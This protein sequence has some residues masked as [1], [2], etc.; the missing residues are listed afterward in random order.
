[1]FLRFIELIFQQKLVV[2]YLEQMERH[3][4][5]IGISHKTQ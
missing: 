5:S 2:P 1:M 4:G 3:S